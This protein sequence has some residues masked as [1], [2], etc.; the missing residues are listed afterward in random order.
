[1][2]IRVNGGANIGRLYPADRC[3][4]THTYN[5]ATEQYD[6]NGAVF[7]T[8]ATNVVSGQPNAPLTIDLGSNVTLGYIGK[9]G[10]FV[11]ISEE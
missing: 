8:G 3:T 2:M 11:G 1:M 4:W 6:V 9:S 10:R 7:Y 5:S